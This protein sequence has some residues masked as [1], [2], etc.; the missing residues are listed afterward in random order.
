MKEQAPTT[1]NTAN[2]EWELKVTVGD[3]G[4]CDEDDITVTMNGS[5]GTKKPN[6]TWEFTV[7]S[8][9]PCASSP[10]QGSTATF[11]FVV[12]LNGVFKCGYDLVLTCSNCTVT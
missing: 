3:F 7:I 2:C 4:G 8:A 10:P 1:C 5:L 9:L 12:K 6:G 11:H